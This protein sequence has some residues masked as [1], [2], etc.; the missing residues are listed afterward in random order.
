MLTQ[1]ILIDTQLFN[2][3]NLLWLKIP[4]IHRTDFNHTHRSHSTI[5]TNAIF[6]ML[7][8]K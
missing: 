6:Q 5:E 3:F 4:F 7:C 2:E 1:T 8:S